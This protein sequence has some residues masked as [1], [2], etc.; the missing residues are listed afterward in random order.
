MNNLIIKII[1]VFFLF[2]TMLRAETLQK[3]EISGNK[4]ISDQ[5]IIIFSEL[6]TNEE[7]TKSKLDKVIKNLY[8]T[9]FFRNVIL[10]F[11]NQTLFLKVEE[12]PIIENLQITGIKKQS[13]VE[14][15]K[16][17]LNLAEMKSF[18]Q[19]LLSADINLI[20]NILKTNGYYFADITSS[21][22]LD[23]ELNTI[24][25]KIDVKLGEKAK[26]KKI[27]FLGEKKFKDKRLKEVIASEEHKFWKFISKNVY[28]NQELINLDTRL[29]TNYFKDNGYFNVK[30]ENSFVEF[31]KNSNF[32]L[33]FNITPGKKY[34]FRDFKL[35]L[36]SNY[37]ANQF[38]SITKKFSKLRGKT[39]SLLKINKILDDINDIALTR[40][41]EFINASIIENIKD[42]K[43]DFEIN[44]TESEK[45]YIEKINING[46]FATL[47]EVIRNNLIIDE[48]DP[49]NE[50]LFN[51]SINN[52]QSL[53]IF[54]KV[55]TDIKKGSS[56]TFKEI[57]LNIE[58]RPTGE[59][60]LTAGFGT[61]G[62]TI[63]GG[64][65]ENNFLGKGIKLDTNL[66][67]TADSIKGKF[68]YAKPNFNYTDNTLFTSIKS[69]TSDFL[70]DFGY[71]T[72]EIGFS[73]GT[74]FEQF[75]NIY[76][77]PEIDFLIEDLETSS[78][79]SKTLKKQEGSYTDLYFNYSINQDLRDKK[80]NTE[81]GYVTNFAQELPIISD[82]AELSN[83]IEITKFQ[84]LS[85]RSDMVGKVS[86]YGKT[87]TGLNDDV[88]IS[89]RLNIPSFRLR[90]FEKG[91]VGPIENNDYIGGNHISTLNLSA[92]L[93]NIF[94]GLD[95]LDVGVFFDA[96]N[97]WGVDYDSSIDDNSKIR[98]S[99]GVALNLMTPIGPLSFSF[100][101]PIS[102]A[103]S[104]KTE[105]FRFNLGTQF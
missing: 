17:K 34:L 49:F 43:I 60:S 89:K 54:K 98:S 25:I 50:I 58:E 87:I 63:G 103:S 100:A 21:K 28:I 18:N 88:R 41:Y 40:Q 61:D 36:P 97:V 55:S 7:I 31:D 105:T 11:E 2:T 38:E 10:S 80:Y 62:E 20:Y 12:N 35:N 1:I 69:S 94:E 68:I 65:K 19:E 15:I 53:G 95:N 23:D 102:K 75:Q 67:L 16:G 56:D 70:T 33:I 92:T 57:D 4:R 45:F 29:L 42:D 85:T 44:I 37:D 13:L 84:K 52:I 27:V 32:N 90:G 104:D 71:K 47:E 8:Q 76:L 77:R 6:K 86:F 9:N 101:N 81:S 14:F 83:A 5:T 48:G 78:K 39:Y 26:I 46:N 59:I 91:K 24:D 51:K 72:S 93:P 22:S 79:A 73:L 3:F 96:A 64:I 99:T 82:N 74:R 66:E 30:V